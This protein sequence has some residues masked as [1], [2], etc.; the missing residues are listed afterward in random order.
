MDRPASR[1]FRPDTLPA[2]RRPVVVTDETPDGAGLQLAGDREIVLTLRD[3]LA[4]GTAR[5]IADLLNDAVEN[6]TLLAG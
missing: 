1:R 6:V 4:A 5:E 2:S 3:D